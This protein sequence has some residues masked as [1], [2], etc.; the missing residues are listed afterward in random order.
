M[1][2]GANVA[3]VIVMLLVGYSYHLH[4]ASHPLLS[5]VGMVFPFF[6]VAN[7]LFMVFWLV[8][9]WTR[10]WVPVAGFVLAYT[11]I[12]VYMPLHTREEVPEGSIRLMTY[13]VCGYG[14]NFKYDNGFNVVLDYIEQQKADIVCVQEDNDDKNRNV[15]AGYEKIGL[16]HNDTITLMQTKSNSNSLGIHTRFPIVKRERI[17]YP[18]KTSNGS[19]A[20]W[21]KVNGDTLIVVNNHFESCHLTKDDR[22]QYRQM[23]KG[24]MDSDSVRTESKVLLVKLAEANAKRSAQID[25]VKSYIDEHQAYDFIVCGDFNDNPL[26]YS[27]HVMAQQLTDC[28]AA[29]G[30][31]LGLSYYQKGFFFRI[32]HIF[33]SPDIQPYQCVVDSEIDASDHYPLVCWLKIGGKP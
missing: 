10:A 27:R 8:F 17:E 14:G 6:L 23:L 26:S 18:T 30:R 5:T 4:P 29:T 22:E 7:L 24:Q 11:P 19:V 20:W 9:K 1:V 32:D 2:T 16:T 13:N 25:C 31:G 15:F 28:F 33:C 12:S 3:T 21:L